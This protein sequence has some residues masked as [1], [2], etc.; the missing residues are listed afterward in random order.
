[1]SDLDTRSCQKRE[2]RRHDSGRHTSIKQHHSGPPI[3]ENI[4]GAR[5]P[6][7]CDLVGGFLE[8]NY[9]CHGYRAFCLFGANVI[10]RRK[11]SAIDDSRPP[12]AFAWT[13]ACGRR[14]EFQISRLPETA[15][16]YRKQQVFG[17]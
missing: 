5:R 8:G 14:T 11:K 4:D 15:F 6:L 17:L 3:W 7:G 2:H 10:R 12:L 1:V 9:V 13:Y 16:G